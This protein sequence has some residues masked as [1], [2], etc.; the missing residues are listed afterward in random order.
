LTNIIQEKPGRFQKPSWLGGPQ[1]INIGIVSLTEDGEIKIH[2]PSTLCY[3]LI[4][5][6]VFN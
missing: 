1:S 5:I 4:C 2:L 6:L 3:I